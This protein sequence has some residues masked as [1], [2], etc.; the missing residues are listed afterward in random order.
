MGR[1]QRWSA[2]RRTKELEEAGGRKRIEYCRSLGPIGG[3]SKAS[4][5]CTHTFCKRTLEIRGGKMDEPRSRFLG[6]C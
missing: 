2:G 4:R 3:P 1:R 6:V 5:L